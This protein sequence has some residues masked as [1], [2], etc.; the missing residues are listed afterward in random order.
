MSNMPL[1]AV[2]SLVISPRTA[3]SCLAPDARWPASSLAGRRGVSRCCEGTNV[4]KIDT[5]H[6]IAKVCMAISI[7]VDVLWE[8]ADLCRRGATARTQACYYAGSYGFKV[9]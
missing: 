8:E 9:F 6:T 2:A 1:L 5:L 4:R 7:P 3:A